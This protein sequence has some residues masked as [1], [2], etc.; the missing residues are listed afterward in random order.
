MFTSLNL[1]MLR[2]Q[3]FWTKKTFP[4]IYLHHYH[5]HTIM[6]VLHLPVS[7]HQFPI[8]KNNFMF[9]KVNIKESLEY[10]ELSDVPL[11]KELDLLAMTNLCFTAFKDLVPV[12]DL[13]SHFPFWAYRP[14]GNNDRGLEFVQVP[15]V[16]QAGALCLLSL[17]EASNASH[18]V[19]PF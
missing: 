5:L 6:P 3:T 4:L 11:N 7:E 1:T 14:K 19:I 18:L 10:V 16:F 17:Q 2:D 9:V 8:N 12:L 13:Q 15:P